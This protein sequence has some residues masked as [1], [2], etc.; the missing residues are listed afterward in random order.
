MDAVHQVHA[1]LCPV[2]CRPFR[3]GGQHN[4]GIH[5]F[6]CIDLFSTASLADPQT[7]K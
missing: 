5:D 2:R 7:S 4:F 6:R 3:G 1:L